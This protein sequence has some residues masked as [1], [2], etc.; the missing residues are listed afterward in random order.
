MNIYALYYDIRRDHGVDKIVF[1]SFSDDFKSNTMFTI[2]G[3][4]LN[5]YTC[6]VPHDYDDMD[7]GDIE[8]I[9]RM[10]YDYDKSYFHIGDKECE[11]VGCEIEESEEKYYIEYYL[12]N[13]GVIELNM[14]PCGYLFDISDNSQ[15]S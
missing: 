9:Y 2:K 6:D 8:I 3:C 7:L 10:K 14:M 11:L 13:D 5:T 15:E 4:I 12:G 1:Y